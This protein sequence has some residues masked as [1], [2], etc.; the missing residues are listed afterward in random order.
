MS[1]DRL[2]NHAIPANEPRAVVP[3]LSRTATASP[4]GHAPLSEH[5]RFGAL[6]GFLAK[7]EVDAIFKQ[8]PFRTV[9]GEEPLELWRRYDQKRQGFARSPSG[10]ILP[11]PSTLTAVEQEVR[12]RRTF[13]QYYE[14]VADYQ[15]G[16]API[17]ALLS[18]QWPVDLDYVD[19]LASQLRQPASEEDQLRFALSEGSIH[20][21]IIGGNQVLFTTSRRDLH[22]DHIP[23]V[24]QVDTDEYEIVIR[25]TSRPNYINIAILD[26]R[27][28]LTN[29]VHKVCALQK[30]GLANCFCVYRRIDSLADSGIN[31][32][33]S[34]FRDS[35][36]KGARPAMVSD[37]LDASSSVP[38]YIRSMNQIL[39]IAVSVGTMTIPALPGN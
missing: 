11:L 36:F 27:L 20:E 28:L 39:Q 29:G 17:R 5:R 21:P 6:L 10:K 23:E 30:A 35:V 7:G 34:I 19:E 9:G 13:K 32:Q 12:Q 14:A 2:A 3:A 26:N 1:I 37:F 4:T 31:V 33:T 16:L 18:P 8:Q 15:F 25:A 38:L 22:A 24:R